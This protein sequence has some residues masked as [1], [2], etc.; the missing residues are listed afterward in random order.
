LPVALGFMV[1]IAVFCTAIGTVVGSIL[2]DMQGFPLIMNFIVLPLFFF[3]SAL[4]PLEGL[5]KPLQI[6]VRVNPLSYGVDGLRGALS[7]D[8]AF[9]VVTDAIVLGALAAVLLA[10]AAYLFSRI[11]L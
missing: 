9:G 3:S 10:I 7:R 11:E 6:G 8:F 5:P 1:L 2:Q 4:F